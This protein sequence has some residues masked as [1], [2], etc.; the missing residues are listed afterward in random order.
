MV[1]SPLKAISTNNS[2]A[3]LPIASTKRSKRKHQKFSDERLVIDATLPPSQSNS[4]EHV[5]SLLQFLKD[6]ASALQPPNPLRLLL[7]DNNAKH[8]QQINDQS[9]TFQEQSLI[10]ETLNELDRL[11]VPNGMGGKA[12]SAEYEKDQIEVSEQS[13]KNS[14]ADSLTL[15]TSQCNQF[16]MTSPNI[17]KE[18]TTDKK[19]SGFKTPPADEAMAESVISSP[20]TRSKKNKLDT[21]QSNQGC[22]ARKSDSSF[23]SVITEY[24]KDLNDTKS[25]QVTLTPQGSKSK[26]ADKHNVDSLKECISS[27]TSN[28]RGGVDKG[29]RH[30][31]KKK[32]TNAQV[33]VRKL[34][35]EQ[36]ATSTVNDVGEQTPSTKPK[37]RCRGAKASHSTGK[38][39]PIVATML[40]HPSF[41]EL[42]GNSSPKFSSSQALS[43]SESAS[44][45]AKA[46]AT[47]EKIAEDN[48]EAVSPMT[49]ARRS[50]R[51]NSKR[52]SSEPHAFEE[53]ASR[54][55]ASKMETSEEKSISSDDGPQHSSRKKL[56]KKEPIWLTKYTVS[57]HKNQKTADGQDTGLPTPA[58]AVCNLFTKSYSRRRVNREEVISNLDAMTTS[59]LDPELVKTA[60]TSPP[61]DTSVFDFIPS[62]PSP[63]K[64]K[65]CGN[66][67]KPA[68]TN[69]FGETKGKRE[70][71]KNTKKALIQKKMLLKQLNADWGI[72]QL[73][74]KVK[75][76]DEISETGDGNSEPPMSQTTALR[77]LIDE[78]DCSTTLTIESEVPK[79]RCRF[80]TLSARKKAMRSLTST[81]GDQNA[82]PET[83]TEFSEKSG[84]ELGVSVHEVTGERDESTLS[85]S[86]NTQR[87]SKA[88]MSYASKVANEGTEVKTRDQLETRSE[89][90]RRVKEN[91]DYDSTVVPN[92]QPVANLSAV[93]IEIGADCLSP[94]SIRV[95]AKLTPSLNDKTKEL[96]SNHSTTK[97]PKDHAATITDHAKPESRELARIGS[98]TLSSNA[99]E[100]NIDLK[101]RST[102]SSRR[103]PQSKRTETKYENCA[104]NSEPSNMSTRVTKSPT[105]ISNVTP[106]IRSRRTP[107][108]KENYRQIDRKA[109]GAKATGTSLAGKTTSQSDVRS[110]S[111][112]AKSP[113]ATSQDTCTGLSPPI[114]RGRRTR[115]IIADSDS[116][117]SNTIQSPAMD[118]TLSPLVQSRRRA[119]KPLISSA[120]ETS[121]AS[122]KTS[123]V[124]KFSNDEKNTNKVAKNS[125]TSPRGLIKAPIIKEFGRPTRNTQIGEKLVFTH[126]SLSKEQKKCVE[127]CAKILDADVVPNYSSAVT[128]VITSVDGDLCCP[129]TLKY[130]LALL[131]GK[132]ILSIEWVTLCLEETNRVPE[133]IFEVRGSSTA[134]KSAAS[135]RSRE[136]FTRG[137]PAL[138]SGCEFYLAGDFKPP[139]PPRDQLCQLI[140]VGG[141]KLLN[142]LPREGSSVGAYHAPKGGRL[143][144]CG[145]IILS[146]KHD[147]IK[148]PSATSVS[149]SWLLDCIAQYQLV[150]S[151]GS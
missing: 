72:D 106:R 35:S 47:F 85:S 24:C 39:I 113:G 15:D 91:L 138:L 120:S 99:A 62:Q 10:V 58:E 23:H 5:Q 46:A 20:L 34:D 84:H 94:S 150:D 75:V 80:R 136:A 53:V 122:T 70:P 110:F 38:D 59:S 60:S 104:Q 4:T 57:R 66:K 128:H 147:S 131:E 133:S 92:R 111:G 45:S 95:E 118:T 89:R 74:E 139:S 115:V 140:K 41:L 27:T 55:K 121:I 43:T 116:Q 130:M 18:I 14:S 112:V 16:A 36:L 64:S 81:N 127:N 149:P 71:R 103:G 50:P 100:G 30:E 143:S 83:S 109:K 52:K 49:K 117:V 135:S 142:R 1:P 146:T 88:S 151:A 67:R 93:K 82:S 65:K 107:D 77:N 124:Q 37:R 11:S 42:M 69:V 97:K 144:K 132:W 31:V 129:R 2:C 119:K 76:I 90:L 13:F 21:K 8:E 29:S 126:T 63:V 17:S 19:K 145:T 108:G 123:K 141:A 68:N 101:L 114:K 6:P 61:K 54:R 51:I 40:D 56:R 9:E 73:S 78:I 32:L 28:S 86:K 134:P 102:R 22:K 137:E 105:S 148:I 25:E 7:P 44:I 33:A 87:I 79:K 3:G 96:K 125:T 12:P 48:T 26:L 98:P